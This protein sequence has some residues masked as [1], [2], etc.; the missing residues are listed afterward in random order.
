MTLYRWSQIAAADATADFSINW[1]EGQA[2]SSVNDSGRAMMAATAKYRDDVAGAITT[3]GSST[4]YTV[5]SY[6]AF[7]T[8]AHLNGQTI[9]FTVHISN[10]AA[11][12]LNV[13]GL[14]AKP[15]RITPANALPAGV[16]I[17]GTPYTVTYNNSDGA[18][19]LHG[20]Y[21]TPYSIP[22]GATIE[23]WGTSAP[24]SSFIFPA[25]QPISR[26][27]YSSLFSLFGTTYG[28]GDGSTTFNVPDL[29]GRV[30]VMKE[31]VATR[32]TSTYF[33]GNSTTLG[34]TG[35]SDSHTLT[36]AQL[37]PGITSSGTFPVTGSNYLSGLNN[38]LT[39]FSTASGGGTIWLAFV[40]STT[41][42]LSNPTASGTVTSNNTSGNAHANVQPTIICNKILRII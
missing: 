3:S 28:S 25:G 26:T 21:D 36:L 19:Y 20:F 42:T 9:A 10:G 1:Q 4:A 14:G 32:L 6:Q 30:P 23:Y 16:L 11:P 7:D 27:T 22:I 12:T 13:D 15:L 18:F 5:A 24:T 31:A 33:G 29:T 8:L 17:Q 39:S 35:G 37:P 41:S 34:A 40:P 2:P 38:F